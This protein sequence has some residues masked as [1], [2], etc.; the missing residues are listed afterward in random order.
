MSFTDR[1]LLWFH[2][3]FVIFAIGPVTI[4]IMSTPRYIRARNVGVLRYLSRMT[5]IFGAASLGVLLFGIIAGQSLHDMTK[6]WVT[7]SM[8]L[9]VVALVLLLLIM[10]DQHRA[11]VAVEGS[12]AAA[13]S[14]AVA[15]PA[16]AA[17]A[18]E[19]APADSAMSPGTEPTAADVEP[20]PTPATATA[21]RVSVA[22]VERGRIASLAG[23]VS[24]IWLVILV[25]MVWRP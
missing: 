24:L 3:G 16:A 17:R 2:I 21:T 20:A 8:T 15:A 9:F 6:T 25:L 23:V 19:F 1:L 4:A 14:P 18:A 11:I 10:R 22:T 12:L 7:A 5:R 13:E